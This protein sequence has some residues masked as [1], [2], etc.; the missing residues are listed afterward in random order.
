[1]TAIDILILVIVAVGGVMG[2]SKGLMSQAGQIAAVVLGIISARFFGDVLAMLFAGNGGAPSAMDSVCGYGVAFLL[3]YCLAWLAARAVKGVIHTV[4]LGI[5]D[6]LGGAVFKIVQ[7]GLI[8]SLALNF[9][10][11]VSGDDEQLHDPE[12]PWRQASVDFAPAVL[13]YLSEIT[14]NNTDSSG[15]D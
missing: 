10:L 1:M 3:A 12:S 9:Y 11:L 6:R 5:I 4:H 7:W 8:L 15:V 13:G 14:A 2:F